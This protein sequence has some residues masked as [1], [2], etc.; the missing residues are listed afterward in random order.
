MRIRLFS[1]ALAAVC[2]ASALGRAPAD[3]PT[4]DDVLTKVRSALSVA[5]FPPDHPG[6][7]ATGKIT[8]YGVETDGE[9]IVDGRGRIRM[10]SSGV[11]GEVQAFDG[12]DSWATDWSGATR[13]LQLQDRDVSLMSAALNTS[14]WAVKPELFELSVVAD[15]NT[16]KEMVLSVKLKDGLF[17]VHVTIDRATG[18]PTKATGTLRD[19]PYTFT[20]DE[21]ES[22]PGLK[23]P[24][25]WTRTARGATAEAH[26]DRV[27]KVTELPANTFRLPTRG[28]TTAEFDPRKSGTLTVKKVATGHLLVKPTIAGEDV[29]WF[30]F[31]SGAGY[32]CFDKKLVQKLKMERIGEVPVGGAVA[33]GSKSAIVRASSLELG[34][35]TFKQPLGVELDLQLIGLAMRESISGIIGYPLF[36]S[37]IVEIECAAP[38]ITLHE[39]AHFKLPDG[40]AW[41]KLIID[42]FHPLVEATYEGDRKGWF[43]M[44]TG[45]ADNVSFHTPTV[46]KHKLLEGRKTSITVQGGVGGIAA[47]KTG[48]IDW[49]ELGGHRFEKPTVS[50]AQ[51]DKGAFANEYAD[52]NLGQAFFNPFRLVFHFSGERVAFVKRAAE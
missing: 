46:R 16:D 29:G 23:L 50:F 12:A 30:I 36:Q 35:V 15:Q 4:V 41:Q 24:R 17:K 5:A 8:R 20:F 27:E 1:A 47:A 21:F 39:P 25:H 45:M 7:K 26:Y 31:D 48:P 40:A 43:L 52:G 18:L 3:A 19:M 37:A 38:A 22:S 34:P 32:T 28:S 42:S 10:T 44:D 13:H 9:L 2:I 33:S 6:I 14:L 49:F 51:A 11:L